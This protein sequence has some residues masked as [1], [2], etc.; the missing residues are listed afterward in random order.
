MRRFVFDR[1]RRLS[2]P[3]LMVTHDPD[4][5]ASA[6]GAVLHLLAGGAVRRAGPEGP[7]ADA[8]PA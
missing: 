6:A 7:L 4:D 3:V 8:L 5:A 2:L 1:A